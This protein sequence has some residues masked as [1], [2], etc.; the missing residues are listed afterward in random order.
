MRIATFTLT[1]ALCGTLCQSGCKSD[2]PSAAGAELTVLADRID[3]PLRA[4]AR[5]DGRV[6]VLVLGR[7]QWLAT[8]AG[9]ET[10]TAQNRSADRLALRAQTIAQLKKLASAARSSLLPAN[11]PAEAQPIELWIL[12]AV[13]ARLTREEIELAARNDA[14]AYQ[15]LLTRLPPAAP[16]G[17]AV[18]VSPARAPFSAA[19]KRVSWNLEQLG[20]PA[21][22][23]QGITGEGAV[24]GLIDDA[25]A[26][27]HG[28]LRNNIWVN[29]DEVPGNGVDDDRNGYIDDRHGYNFSANS[30]NTGTPTSQ[31]GTFVA[32]IA[33]GDGS[34]GTLT[35][36]APRA[37][38]MPLP[39][40]SFMDVALAYQYALENGADVIN[41]SFSL[42]NQGNLRGAWRIASDH[43]T[44]AGLVLVS[45]AGNFQQSERVP[46][47]LRI[48][49]D[50]P[51][52]IAVGGV[53]E[54]Q[55]LAP[56]SSMGPV[57]WGSVRFFGDHSMPNGLV[58]PDV[59]AFPGPNYPI[60]NPAGGY[61]DPNV[62]TR[63]NSFSSPHVAGAA[64][65]LL[66]A[67]PRTPAWR[68]AEVLRETA[69]DIAP[70]GKDNRTG[71]GLIDLRAALNRLTGTR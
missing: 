53:D 32:G 33:A 1:A 56:F 60:L 26:L 59:V 38:I 3:A 22:W 20:A 37:R 41:M 30:P 34:G 68:I 27:S 70:A 29:D 10:F 18:L 62:A 63:G 46:V 52:V 28:D 9:F 65:L 7:R 50:I 6:P 69:H 4:A 54:Q 67:R 42:P 39:G 11:L 61:F 21:L 16:S 66:S 71:N 12:N 49:E 40:I 47:Q 17:A 55:N 36:V 35:G 43:A 24:I 23:S 2:G 58:K 48:P 25:I 31:H 51:S 14:V 5:S 45:G 44:A 57:E 15:Y 19:G 64:A 13:A 8:P